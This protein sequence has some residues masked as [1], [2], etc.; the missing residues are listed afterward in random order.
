MANYVA[1]MNIP[2]DHRINLSV[3]CRDVKKDPSNLLKLCD[4]HGLKCVSFELASTRVVLF[5]KFIVPKEKSPYI[6]YNPSSTSNRKHLKTITLQVT[7]R[8]IVTV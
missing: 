4:E 7:Q 3:V 2:A 8:G 1:S 5:A 6:S